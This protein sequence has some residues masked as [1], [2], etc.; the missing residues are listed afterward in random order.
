MISSEI[1]ISQV[2]EVLFAKTLRHLELANIT[3][4]VIKDQ[5]NTLIVVRMSD[6]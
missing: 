1:E 6:N 4:E 3:V 2:Q 5:K